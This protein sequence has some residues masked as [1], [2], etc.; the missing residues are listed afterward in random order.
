MDMSFYYMANSGG[1]LLGTVLYGL[2]FQVGGLARM[3]GTAA[4]MVAISA[5]AAGCLSGG[6]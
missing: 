5:L 1:R 3:L 4:L 6:S 2:T